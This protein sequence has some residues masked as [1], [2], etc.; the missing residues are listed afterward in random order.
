METYT[1]IL[2]ILLSLLSWNNN[3]VGERF[4]VFSQHQV[5]VHRSYSLVIAYAMCPTKNE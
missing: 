2:N 4:L 1:E 3:F 5:T